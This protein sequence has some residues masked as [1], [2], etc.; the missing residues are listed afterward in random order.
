VEVIVA[1]VDVLVVCVNTVKVEDNDVSFGEEDMSDA[2]DFP[3]LRSESVV[4]SGLQQF[5]T[6]FI[7]SY[8]ASQISI[9]AK[10]ARGRLIDPLSL[11]S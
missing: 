9:F 3:E 5:P 6:R 1:I 4:Q 8:R 10:A 2:V 11:A 7:L